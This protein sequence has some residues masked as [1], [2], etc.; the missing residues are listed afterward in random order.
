MILDAVLLPGHFM[1]LPL[2]ISSP[3]SMDK[4]RFTWQVADCFWQEIHSEKHLHLSLSKY[5]TWLDV[6]F[7]YKRRK[8]VQKIWCQRNIGILDAHYLRSNYFIEKFAFL[9]FAHYLL[10]YK[11]LSDQ[12]IFIAFPKKSNQLWQL[13]HFFFYY[14]PEIRQNMHCFSHMAMTSINSK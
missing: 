3:C 8:V 1:G 11:L 12:H 9:M 10:F 7:R 13:K 5:Y 4:Y 6:S 14:V 2:V